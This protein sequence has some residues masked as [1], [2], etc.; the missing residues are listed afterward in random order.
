[1]RIVLAMIVCAA[2]L[3]APSARAETRVFILANNADGYGVDRCLANGEACGAGLANAYCKLRQFST[4]ASYRKIERTE[5]TGMIQ[6]SA[7]TA[8]R[9]ATCE[10]Y[11]AIVCSR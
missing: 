2:V 8:C 6:T 11:V 3:V 9:G 5:I 1:M 10:D 4:A 7:T